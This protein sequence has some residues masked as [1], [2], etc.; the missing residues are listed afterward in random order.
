MFGIIYSLYALTRLAIE[1]AIQEK[2]RIDSW[3]FARRLG[4][5]Y[6]IDGRG[7]EWWENE[8]CYTSIDIKTGHYLIKSCKTHKIL[9]DET[10][11]KI[12]VKNEN[13]ETKFNN[14]WEEAI[15]EAEDNNRAY[16]Y[17]ICIGD[18]RD[19][20]YELSTKKR[21]YTES[22]EIPDLTTN[23]SKFIRYKYYFKEN[24]KDKSIIDWSSKQR[25]SEE[26]WRSLAGFRYDGKKSIGD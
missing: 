26:E 22:I 3:D 19:G 16:F 1:S 7:R 24:T 6:Y 13:N 21:I 11:N 17:V 20:R 4:K 8:R 10:Q 12:D 25:I 14:A 15:K 9:F 18:K 2:E 23:K 5:S